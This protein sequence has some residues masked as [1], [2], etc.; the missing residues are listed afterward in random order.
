[1]LS[2]AAAPLF[3]LCQ[4]HSVVA[5]VSLKPVCS[6]WSALTG[7]SR[8][9]FNSVVLGVAEGGDCTVVPTARLNAPFLNTC[10]VRFLVD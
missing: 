6:D 2:I 5:P 1:M 8:P 4:K 7:L 3:T 9:C 10:C